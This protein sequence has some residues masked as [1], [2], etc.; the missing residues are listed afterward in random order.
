MTIR[1]AALLL[2]AA[3]LAACAQT[4]SNAPVRAAAAPTGDQ[5]FD[6]AQA[7]LA[8]RKTVKPLT[9]RAKNVILFIAD[10][11]DPTT[12]AAARIYDGQTRGEE[13]EEN[14]L[15]FERFPNLAMSK[16]YNTDAQTPDSAGTMSAMATGYKTRAGI[17]SLKKEA[18]FGDCASA[19]GN[20]A[21]TL[22]EYAET[23]GLATGV[24][25]T[26]RLTHAT[27]AATYAH[28]PSR[29]WERDISLPDGAYEQ[30][31]RDIASQL[32][33]F[34]YGDGVDVAMGGGRP[35]FLTEDAQDPEY[36]D[37]KG[38]RKDGRN[39]AAEWVAKS[40]RHQFVWNKEQFDAIDPAA[41]PRVLG[42]F[43]M[44]HMQYEADR[45]NDSAGEPSLEEMTKKA[46]EILSRDADGFVLVVEA[47][48]VD[49]A[50]HDGNAAR[51]L[52]D[53]QEFSQ[54]IAAARAM[55]DERDTLI[56]AT[57]DHGHTL[58]FAGYPL[59]GS[60]ILG[61]ATTSGRYDRVGD[62][63]ARADDGKTYTTLGYANGPGAL[64]KKGAD[65][66]KGRPEV[67]ND[68]AMS[69][70]HLQQSLAPMGDETHGGQDVTIYASG[71]GAWLFTGVVE[72]NYIF[73]VIDD[74]LALKAR[75][76]E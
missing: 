47:G 68:E 9:G 26:A 32:I 28:S 34:D 15:S 74:A 6:G 54:A 42:L 49:H 67:G 72:Q 51:A 16:T 11:M 55:T 33:D 45:A 30:G 62:G 41:D 66:S 71:P 64:F 76:Q 69:I 5:W 18:E 63:F 44:S 39:L 19:K 50:H 13:G 2:S 12:V 58:S 53:A 43:E 52:I 60:P 3:A 46:I 40:D 8:Q 70:D 4:A 59:K 35:N 7:A 37:R 23:A 48:R 27:P 65:L 24:I 14:L 1:T 31:C 57:A 22:V 75:A 20:E 56:V 21:A 61:L 38:A 36:P 29:D 17:I 25:S 10:G 73:H